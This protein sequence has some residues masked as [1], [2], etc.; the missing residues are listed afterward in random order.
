MMKEPGAAGPRF[1]C[2]CVT[3]YQHRI[4][5]F[6]S[7]SEWHGTIFR[8]TLAYRR[9]LVPHSHFRHQRFQIFRLFH[10]NTCCRQQ[11]T[12]KLSHLLLCGF[13]FSWNHHQQILNWLV[14]QSISVY[15]VLIH[16]RLPFLFKSHHKS[17]CI[18]EFGI[19][20]CIKCGYSGIVSNN[21]C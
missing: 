21:A 17:K 3:K 14:V 2:C 9:H 13:D 16:Y 18:S 19:F 20:L 1:L 5:D 4:W 8:C 15:I 12:E 10:L 11:L 6:V 7:S